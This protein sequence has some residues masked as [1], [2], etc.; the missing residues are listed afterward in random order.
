VWKGYSSDVSTE[1]S[2]IEVEVW[3]C[4]CALAYLF[5]DTLA[6]GVSFLSM[7]RKNE[8]NRTIG[9]FFRMLSNHCLLCSMDSVGNCELAFYAIRELQPN[10]ELTWDYGDRIR[11]FTPIPCRCG[12]KNYRKTLPCYFKKKV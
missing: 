11:S 10:E 8:V 9:T 7:G 4:L 1:N 12:A 3:C 2:G 6:D 5:W